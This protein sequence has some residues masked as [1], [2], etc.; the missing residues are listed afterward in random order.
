MRRRALVVS[1][2]EYHELPQFGGIVAREATAFAQFLEDSSFGDFRVTVSGN[3]NANTLVDR[4]RT[5]FERPHAED[6][7][8]FYFSGH[9]RNAQGI[10]VTLAA[11]DASADDPSSRSLSSA[12]LREFAV[13]SPANKISL[14]LDCCYG[15]GLIAEFSSWAA[16]DS[17]RLEDLNRR[18]KSIQILCSG[19]D[20]FVREDRSEFTRSIL[21]CLRNGEAGGRKARV[22]LRDIADHLLVLRQLKSGNQAAYFERFG[23]D[24]NHIISYNPN[25]NSV[26]S[27]DVLADLF[28]HDF[29]RTMDAVKKLV[30]IWDTGP[31]EAKGRAAAILT[32]YYNREPNLPPG[33]RKL[34]APVAEAITRSHAFPR[35]KTQ[36]LI[37]YNTRNQYWAKRAHYFLKTER[38]D[39]KLFD[40]DMAER[41]VFGKV[42]LLDWLA[43]GKSAVWIMDANLVAQVRTRRYE[44]RAMLQ[45]IDEH[46]IKNQW[47]FWLDG[48]VAALQSALF[49]RWR[50]ISSREG[51]IE[52]AC[53]Q[54]H[55]LRIDHVAADAASFGTAPIDAK[56]IERDA[57]AFHS[58]VEYQTALLRGQLR[59][60]GTKPVGVPPREPKFLIFKKAGSFVMAICDMADT[61]NIHALNRSNE[62]QVK[63][64]TATAEEL[65]SLGFKARLVDP[66][67]T[68][69][70]RLIANIYID[71]NIFFQ[72][73]MFPRSD[74][75]VPNY[76]GGLQEKFSPM[77]VS[78]FIR[79]L[80]Q[81]HGDDK[82]VFANITASKRFH[83]KVL[84]SLLRQRHVFTRFAP[85]PSNSLHIGSL[86][87]AIIS[88][89]CSLGNSHGSRFH[90]RFDDT[91]V[92]KDVADQNISVILQD[93]KWA[94]INVDVHYRQAEQSEP[95][96]YDL[97]MNILWRAGLCEKRDDGSIH[98]NIQAMDRSMS[99]WL[100]VKRGPQI[101]HKVPRMSSSKRELDYSLTW[102]S[103]PGEAP[104]YKY[105]F[106]GAVDD[107]V[108][109]SLVIRDVRQDHSA[110][111][112]R[113]S[114]LMG[115]LRDSLA[116]PQDSSSEFLAK[117]LRISAKKRRANRHYLRP[118]PF[119]CPPVYLH[120]SRVCDENGEQL[121][122]RNLRPEHSIVYLRKFGTFFPETILAW[123]LES[124][125]SKIVGKL[126]RGSAEPLRSRLVHLGIST[127]LS[128]PF[129]GSLL[130]PIDLFTAPQPEVIRIKGLRR[131]D[132]LV[133]QDFSPVQLA[134]FA[135]RLFEENDLSAPPHLQDVL[136]RLHAARKAFGGAADVSALLL[137][138]A[139]LTILPENK[140]L[141]AS[142]SVAFPEGLHANEPELVKWLRA[143]P[144]ADL[145]RVRYC[146]MNKA[147]GPQISILVQV[148]GCHAVLS[149]LKKRNLS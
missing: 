144:A 54:M 103:K 3:D 30:G 125:G 9:G 17:S 55:G 1:I 143:L 8:L 23:F 4:V 70:H 56:T 25:R 81:L 130:Q 82:I 122:K 47:I 112:A 136:T 34:V 142:L 116:F 20:T 117:Q 14:I 131:M 21:E 128:A 111:T 53:A 86:R 76:E 124:L 72:Y 26:V 58:A 99:Y 12:T 16:D 102:P 63:A 51:R 129:I 137:S 77:S 5:F 2:E 52:V 38:Y 6:D 24:Q 147:E 97:V 73:L 68:D 93:L 149:A 89:L 127:F 22:T 146:L 107:V 42:D 15:R 46:A 37:V 100:D 118:F 44:L 83:D 28:S 148:L 98:L 60:E 133:L 121:S 94:G 132:H 108:H 41:Y 36:S 140:D 113:Q 92:E 114:I 11:A 35:S 135:N 145:K 27:T 80:Q 105:K 57:H 138:F 18:G 49:E 10:P 74:I 61:I 79:T 119:P 126:V 115:C 62:P 7:L 101:Q 95:P 91:N 65:D 85:T 43:A 66:L 13:Q 75:V 139:G 45:E 78:S 19:D 33:I 48:N 109:N 104:R 59:G 31:A 110:F 141:S 69:P 120:V 50:V 88:Y 106:A 87:T 90:V 96:L 29:G 32:Q 40:L 84:T 67:F 64:R 71:A 39:S 123:C 134:N